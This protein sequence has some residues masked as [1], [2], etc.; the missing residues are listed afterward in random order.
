MAVNLLCE[1]LQFKNLP[2]SGISH[3]TQSPGRLQITKKLKRKTL[4]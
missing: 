2:S 3:Y 1:Y 4:K